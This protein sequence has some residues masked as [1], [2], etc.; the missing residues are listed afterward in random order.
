MISN[1]FRRFVNTTENK[2]TTDP[3][4]DMGESGI[5]K[6]PRQAAVTAGLIV[7]EYDN[8]RV[9]KNR[10]M[11]GYP[12]G[13][14]IKMSPLSPKWEFVVMCKERM[15]YVLIVFSLVSIICG[16]VLDPSKRSTVLATQFPQKDQ[17]VGMLTKTP[18]S[19]SVLTF[20]PLL[21]IGIPNLIIGIWMVVSMRV[22]TIKSLFVV[23]IQQRYMARLSYY[24]VI[25]QSTILVLTVM[26]LAGV[27]NAYELASLSALTW[28]EFLMYLHSDLANM[29][30]LNN[31]ELV[32]AFVNTDNMTPVAIVRLFKKVEAPN[33]QYN[34]EQVLGAMGMHTF[35]Y[36]IVLIHLIQSMSATNYQTNAS[37][38]SAVLMTLFLQYLIPVVKILQIA[39]VPYLKCFTVYKMVIL[40]IEI[41]EIVNTILVIVLLISA[42]A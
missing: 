30:V 18:E 42:I 5:K 29:E 40:C 35:I 14:T 37:Y 12:T 34:Y 16:S 24:Q 38:D 31:W 39:R 36:I 23:E 32:D 41:I 2:Q 27:I 1:L 22:E 10:T 21:S 6:Q 28:A 11:M 7:P 26:P 13:G 4:N 15:G 19:H 25:I 8:E 3:H 9:I 33:F 20:T 17:T